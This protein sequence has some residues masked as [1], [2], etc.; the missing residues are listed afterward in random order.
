[1]IKRKSQYIA[2]VS[3]TIPWAPQT[4]RIASALLEVQAN[5]KSNIP[6]VG[7]DA[8]I[9]IK[10]SVYNK[11]TIAKPIIVITMSSLSLGNS[12]NFSKNRAKPHQFI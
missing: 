1:M 2:N 7:T 11:I 8:S 5:S 3:W 4:E 9:G 12:L 6:Y 10:T